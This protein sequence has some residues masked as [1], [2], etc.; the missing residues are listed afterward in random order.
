MNAVGGLRLN[1]YDVAIIGGGICGASVAF[2]LSQYCCRVVVLEKENDIACHTTK[3][4]SGIIHAGYDPLPGT[5]MARMNVKGNRFITENAKKLGVTFINTGSLVVAFNKKDEEM[6]NQLF[7]RGRKNGVPDLFIISGEE[8]RVLEPRL[9]G[10][11]TAALWAKTA[12]VIS[13]WELALRLMQNAV[14]N[15][16]TLLRETEVIGIRE[17]NGS[18]ILTTKNSTNPTNSATDTSKG[19]IEASYVVNAAGVAAEEIWGLLSFSFPP[20]KTIPSKGEYY[21]L[22]KSQA[23]IVKGVI[24]QCPNENGKGVLVGITSHGNVIVGPT[25]TRCDGDDTAT[26]AAGLAFAKE[27]ALRLIPELSLR[28]NI[29]NFAGVRATT[30]SE[31]FI[32]AEEEKYPG[33]IHLAGIKSPGLTSAPALAEEVV[34]MLQHRGLSGEKNPHF[35]FLPSPIRPNELS[36]AERIELVKNHPLYGRIICRCEKITEGEIREALDSP[37]PPVSLDGVKRRCKSGMG[38]CQGG[39][40]SVRIHEILAAHMELSMEDVL[41]DRGGTYILTGK[42]KEN[43]GEAL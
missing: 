36:V 9:S 14:H 11:V 24:F 5:A 23:G 37:I 26:T 13:P 32:L 6:L 22:D 28:D 39:F 41:Q 25:A 12:G 31:D 18:Y 16:V 43:R 30:D 40:C 15:G 8:A 2:A 7:E 3:A 35:A 27:S 10:E 1:K 17:Q 21:L 34:E 19:E 33:V 20:F 29:R 38:R 42:T 4:N